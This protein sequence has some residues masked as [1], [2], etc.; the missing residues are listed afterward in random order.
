MAIARRRVGGCERHG[1]RSSR[2]AWHSRTAVAV[3]F[4]DSGF[5]GLDLPSIVTDYVV[6]RVSRKVKRSENGDA[7]AHAIPGSVE[8]E[9]VALLGGSEILLLEGCLG[10]REIKQGEWEA[11]NVD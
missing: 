11:G 2:C 1:Q 10:E 5:F 8:A 9:V 3:G 6:R 4:G 7:E